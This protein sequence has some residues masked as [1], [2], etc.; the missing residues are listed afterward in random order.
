MGE[1]YAAKSNMTISKNEEA[2][3][4]LGTA[5]VRSGTGV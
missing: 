3:L 2:K 1:A 5:G 4:S